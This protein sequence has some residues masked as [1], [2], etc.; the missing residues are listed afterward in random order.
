MVSVSVRSSGTSNRHFA[1][2]AALKRYEQQIAHLRIVITSD[3]QLGDTDAAQA[4]R[5]L[6]DTVTVYRDPSKLGGY[7]VAPEAVADLHADCFSR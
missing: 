7:D 6:V 2:P 1:A 3:M 5:E 4:V